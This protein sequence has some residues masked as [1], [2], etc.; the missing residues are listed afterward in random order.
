MSVGI[1][2]KCPFCESR[3]G[4][5]GGV[6]IAI[7]DRSGGVHVQCDICGAVGPCGNDVGEAI[8]RWNQ[9]G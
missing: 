6:T 3:P 8:E 9:R 2:K 7:F 1:L 5:R 4:L